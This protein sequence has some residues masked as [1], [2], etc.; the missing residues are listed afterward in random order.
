MTD[1]KEIAEKWFKLGINEGVKLP[2]RCRWDSKTF[3]EV[4]REEQE[5]EE[6]NRPT[7]AIQCPQC[8]RPNCFDYDPNH[9]KRIC[10][11]QDCNY[12]EGDPIKELE[13]KFMKC[14]DCD[15]YGV[16]IPYTCAECRANNYNKFTP[17]KDIIA[18]MAKGT[19]KQLKKEAKEEK[20]FLEL[21]KDLP[22]DTEPY[23]YDCI[24]NERD[25]KYKAPNNKC[26][27][28]THAEDCPFK[29]P[30]DTP[31][32]SEIECAYDCKRYPCTPGYCDNKEM[33]EPKPKYT[34]KAAD[35]DDVKYYCTKCKIIHDKGDN[36]YKSHIYYALLQGKTHDGKIVRDGIIKKDTD[37]EDKKSDPESKIPDWQKEEPLGPLK[38][39]KKY[40]CSYNPNTYCADHNCETCDFPEAKLKEKYLESQEKRSEGE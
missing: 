40:Q 8:K 18:I 6:S 38:I 14:K 33:F 19:V 4:W 11:W 10:V 30:I 16:F 24:P 34:K 29:K 39:P 3:E 2:G 15:N 35:S 37:S 26:L 23:L 9:K 12:V 13:P 27:S 7:S 28:K 22:I 20:E 5:K 36:Q 21:F 25:C 1:L 31:D 17:K 32:P